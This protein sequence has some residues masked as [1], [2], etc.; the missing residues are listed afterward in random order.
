[1]VVFTGLLD[2]VENDDEL[3]T[4]LA[5]EMAHAILQHAVSILY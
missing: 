3:A 1:L 5:H 2:F 4:I